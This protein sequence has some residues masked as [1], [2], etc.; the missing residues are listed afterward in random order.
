MPSVVG[1]EKERINEIECGIEGTLY[2]L[3]VL[4]VK[5]VY[6]IIE[7]WKHNTK[8]I[9]YELLYYII[10]IKE[11]RFAKA[12]LKNKFGFLLQKINNLTRN[13]TWLAVL[14]NNFS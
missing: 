14:L 2:E 12:S 11:V 4:G 10:F 1:V 9:S 13:I 5:H 6:E 3:H 8:N 7:Y